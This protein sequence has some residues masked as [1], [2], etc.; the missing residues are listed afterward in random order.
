MYY[1]APECA[2]ESKKDITKVAAAGVVVVEFSLFVVV[3]GGIGGGISGGGG[4]ITVSY[5]LPSLAF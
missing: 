1:E 5:H 3:F 4:I 2:D